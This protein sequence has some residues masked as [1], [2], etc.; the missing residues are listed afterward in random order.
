M[1]GIVYES[2]LS[3]Y[4]N[5]VWSQNQLY[6]YLEKLE[7]NVFL[8]YNNYFRG[9]AMQTVALAL[10]RKKINAHRVKKK[11]LRRHFHISIMNA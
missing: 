6:S 5:S 4:P 1:R 2:R 8:F 11:L 7:S 10:E 9:D 3:T